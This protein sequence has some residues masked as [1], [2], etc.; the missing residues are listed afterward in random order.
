MRTALA[1]GGDLHPLTSRDYLDHPLYFRRAG[2]L[3]ALCLAVPQCTGAELPTLLPENDTDWPDWQLSGAF[4]DSLRWRCRPEEFGM[5]RKALRD[6]WRRHLDSSNPASELDELIRFALIPGHPFAMEHV[7]HP[8]LLTQETPGARDAM[9]SVNL[10]PLWSDEHSNLRQLV[11]WARDANLH[12]AHAD[13]ALPTARLLAWI[14]ATSQ[15]GLR[16]AA[17][18]GLT[19]LLAACPR[20]M[21]AFLTDFL[22]VMMLMFWKRCWWLYGV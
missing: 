14:C 12:G 18:K 7:I 20:V 13:I 19:R 8:R 9:W 3:E 16:L 2:L 17:M 11:I 5:D 10:V 15:N 6:L 22:G 4:S 1:L 21:E